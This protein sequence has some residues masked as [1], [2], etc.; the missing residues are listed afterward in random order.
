[1]HAVAITRAAATAIAFAAVVAAVGVSRPSCPVLPSPMRA[2]SQR[3]VLPAAPLPPPPSSPAPLSASPELLPSPSPL[4]SSRDVRPR[5]RCHHSLRRR[6]PVAA[7][8]AR[9]ADVPPS[10]TSAAS[11]PSK[12]PR[13]R[14][15]RR[16]SRV[17]L[18]ARRPHDRTFVVAAALTRAYVA[19]VARATAVA[20]AC[21][22]AVILRAPSS[23]PLPAPPDVAVA[24]A[25]APLCAVASAFT[26]V[27]AAYI[28]LRVAAVTPSGPP[29]GLVCAWPR[30]GCMERRRQCRH[31]RLPRDRPPTACPFPEPARAF[32]VFCLRNRNENACD[33]IN[34]L[35]PSVSG[36][37]L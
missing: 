13:R 31:H 34:M 28:A 32:C 30:C 11:P 18:S 24:C 29:P 35:R 36:N 20:I 15:L 17:C 6:S 22:V 21:V 23:S 9:V 19:A 14:V 10:L 12:S 1:M 5:R 8:L 33:S 25:V 16:R 4:P 27:C 7:T 3:S 26:T 2:P 37:L